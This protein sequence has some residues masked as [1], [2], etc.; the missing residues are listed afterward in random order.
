MNFQ[1]RLFM[2][3]ILIIST[4]ADEAGAPRHVETIVKG[5]ASNYKFITVFGEGGPV[6]ERLQSSGCTV[7]IID[8]M[9]TAI[10]PIKD[11]IALVKIVLLVFKYKPDLIHCHSAKA[12]MLGRISA[13]ISCTPWVY[14]VHGWGWR[15]L[16]GLKGRLVIFIEKILKHIP[17]GTYIFVANDVMNDGKRVVGIDLINSKVIYNGVSEIES[18]EFP[19]GNGYTILMP[20]RVSSAK[21]HETLIQGF[22]LFNCVKSRLILCGTGTDAPEFIALA[23]HLAPTAFGRIFFLGQS[24]NVEGIYSQCDVFALVSNFEA[25]PLSIIEAMSCGKPIIATAV[26]GIPE[27]IENGRNGILVRLKCVDDVVAA[28]TI[29]KEK[30]IRI[31]HGNASKTIYNKRFTCNLMLNSISNVYKSIGAAIK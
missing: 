30:R 12:G 29:Y 14:T 7:H 1:E 8:Q 19:S 15:G 20:A 4:N 18:S 31:L 3:K 10:N 2:L 21:D 16:S 23:K 11:I 13:F 27:L 5:L 26:G 17:G 6:S 25:L 22:E 24:S 28:L 9:R